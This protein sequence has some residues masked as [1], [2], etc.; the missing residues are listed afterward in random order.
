MNA[1]ARTYCLPSGDV[2]FHIYNEGVG[3]S[4]NEASQMCGFTIKGQTGLGPIDYNVVTGSPNDLEVKFTVNNIA[5]TR[6]QGTLAACGAARG[7]FSYT[8]NTT[9]K[10]FQRIWRSDQRQYRLAHCARDRAGGR[11]RPCLAESFPSSH[12]CAFL[13]HV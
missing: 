4:H 1:L 9:V 6:T 5:Y 3:G 7:T 10:A 11:F 2:Q 13:A 12:F 8:G